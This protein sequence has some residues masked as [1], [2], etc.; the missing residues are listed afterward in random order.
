MVGWRTW[1]IAQRRSL[2][3]RTRPWVQASAKEEE[4]EAVVAAHMCLKGR[5]RLLRCHLS[6][7]ETEVKVDERFFTRA[8]RR[9]KSIILERA[10]HWAGSSCS[11]CGMGAHRTDTVSDTF[12]LKCQLNIK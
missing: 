12:L 11:A 1:P 3:S 5:A 7:K 6:N 2:P 9:M 10:E 8:I 4:E